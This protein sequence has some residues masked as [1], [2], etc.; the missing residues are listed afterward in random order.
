M[1]YLFIQQCCTSRGQ[2]ECEE[3]EMQVIGEEKQSLTDSLMSH[4]LLTY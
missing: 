1:A 3:E 4:C 2:S